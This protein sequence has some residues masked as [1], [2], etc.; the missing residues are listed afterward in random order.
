MRLRKTG[1]L[2]GCALWLLGAGCTSLREIPRGDYTSEPERHNVRLETRPLP[3]LL[4]Y[5][6]LRKAEGSELA[7]KHEVDHQLRLEVGVDD[8]RVVRVVVLDQE[9]VG[10][11]LAVRRRLD[12]KIHANDLRST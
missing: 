7:A 2:L 11:K 3:D 9:R 1:R 12:A 4:M 8:H 5:Y 10:S 6:L